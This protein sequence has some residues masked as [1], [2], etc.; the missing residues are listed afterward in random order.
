MDFDVGSTMRF[1]NVYKTKFSDLEKAIEYADSSGWSFLGMHGFFSSYRLYRGV[2]FV[3]PEYCDGA[4]QIDYRLK[5]YSNGSVKLL[6]NTATG[7]VGES[8]LPSYVY[9]SVSDYYSI[10]AEIDDTLSDFLE[11]GFTI[12][13]H[14]RNNFELLDYEGDTFEPI[15][16]GF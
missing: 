10:R 13:S 6:V 3:Y 2:I 16:S 14:G 11:L 5:I 7:I 9:P 12:A 8:C 1:W 15:A 4:E